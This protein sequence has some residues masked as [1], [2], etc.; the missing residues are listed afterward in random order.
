MMKDNIIG[1]KVPDIR[2]ISTD[3]SFQNLR[4]FEGKNIVLYF[5]PKD[6]TPGC[7]RE[8]K[9]FAE[10]KAE[11]EKLNTQIV[12]VSRDNLVCH[13]KFQA[14]HTLTFPLISDPDEELCKFFNVIIEKNMF[15]RL[16]LGI[17][18]STFLIDKNGIIRQIW[19]SV[20]VKEHANQ[21][22]EA[23]KKLTTPENG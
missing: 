11:F 14:K 6:N 4:D 2:F 3:P 15:A 16:I 10:M 21:V 13:Q 18:R 23:V 20:K 19:R 8:S 9:D 1:Q 5:Y 17:E 12:G 22:Y 7:T